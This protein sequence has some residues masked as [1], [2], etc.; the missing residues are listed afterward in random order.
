M[1]GFTLPSVRHLLNYHP[2]TVSS[3]WFP[4]LWVSLAACE[5][6][7]C[8]RHSQWISKSL[9][10]ELWNMWAALWKITWESPLPWAQEERRAQVLWQTPWAGRGLSRRGE[11]WPGVLE[12]ADEEA[13][14]RQMPQSGCANVASDRLVWT[15]QRAT[16]ELGAGYGHSS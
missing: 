13:K 15:R 1:R 12:R 7:N 6:I 14:W 16:E 3:H 2:G 5:H 8:A 10:V 9:K 11:A 4:P